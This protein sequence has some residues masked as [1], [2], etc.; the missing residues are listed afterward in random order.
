M[1]GKRIDGNGQIA[2]TSG[3][4]VPIRYLDW[5]VEGGDMEEFAVKLRALVV[6]SPDGFYDARLEQRIASLREEKGSVDARK[7]NV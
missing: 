7:E 6:A 3:K 1:L 2:S 4:G 5:L